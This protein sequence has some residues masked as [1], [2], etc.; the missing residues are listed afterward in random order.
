MVAYQL[1]TV[2]LSVATSLWCTSA[3]AQ[4]PPST[5]RPATPMTEQ[6]AYSSAVETATADGWESY[7]K[8]FPRGIHA[9]D[10][11]E[12]LDGI[13]YN[14]AQ[15]VQTDAIA[16]EAIF[17]RCKTSAGADKVFALWDDAAFERAKQLGSADGYSS[18]VVRFPNGKHLAASQTALEGFAW[19]SCTIGG[20]VACQAYTKEYP[21]GM[22]AKE[23]QQK[24]EQLEF[25]AVRSQ[26]TIEG[27]QKFLSSHYDNAEASARLREL[28]YD[29]AL[30]SG[31]LS[32]W[33]NFYDKYWYLSERPATQEVE[34]A[35]KEIDNAEK[36]I[37][38]LLYEQI[39]TGATLEDCEDYQ[40]RFPHDIHS[41]QVKIIKEPL[42]FES[43]KKANTVESYKKYLADYPQGE[44]V[45]QTR[46][47]LD[48]VLFASASKADWYSNYEEY[49]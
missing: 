45:A 7:L 36:E 35:N 3:L 6:Q 49:L 28:L 21:Q 4:L 33:E 2:V 17:R 13:L 24:I 11:R 41:Q 39:V 14:E 9:P 38:R 5:Q 8:R 31:S 46:S 1:A 15:R 30:R 47:L 20:I 10:A 27:Y 22:H 29:K 23:A 26:D 42:L 16:L 34:N 18:Y 43:A 40:K 12:T 48:P 19:Q 44:Y 37:E 32:D 25:A